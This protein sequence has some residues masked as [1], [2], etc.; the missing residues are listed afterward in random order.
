MQTK[1]NRRALNRTRHPGIYRKGDK[2]SYVVMWRDRMGKQHGTARKTL[3][4]ALE[5][6]GETRG[7]VAAP[8]RAVTFA[9]YAATWQ[10][11]YRGRTARGL[12]ELTREDYE[13]S[14]RLYVLPYFGRMRLGG[15]DPPS[16]RA[17]ITSLER[18]GLAP[19]SVRKNFA[20]LRAL[21]ATA[22]EDGAIRSN[23]AVGVRIT[24]RS[25][26]ERE[27]V[28][29][30]GHTELAAFIAATPPPWR[31]FFEFL[32]HSGLRI[33][34]AI[35]LRCG[36]IEF[37]A[38]PRVRVREQLCRGKRRSTKTDHGR[39]D[40]PLS[41]GMAR[42]LWKLCAGKSSESPVFGTGHGTALNASN[43]RTRVL[44]PTRD[45]AGM[46][47]VT[48][49]S[50]RHTCASLLFEAGK[51]AKQVQRWLGHED[52]GFTLKGYIHLL[53]NGL[54]DADFLDGT[55]PPVSAAGVNGGITEAPQPAV[56]GRIPEL[57][58]AA[59]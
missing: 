32:T 48:F 50:F 13:R 11:T 5:F 24:G 47:W 21:F 35:G 28:R 53:D 41:K 19:A 42:R 25:D 16:V 22:L 51:D 58:E 17:F 57:A 59:C 46:P 20:P 23:P 14:M 45:A 34:E 1:A 40:I 52:A 2:G 49:H 39:R 15:I 4:L 44:V 7:G 27:E 12:G 31:L 10:D 9:A 30:L 37:G 38:T 36:D 18:K 33:S 26:E 54:G 8:A 3:A 29:P 6:Q 56:K 55:I 43:V